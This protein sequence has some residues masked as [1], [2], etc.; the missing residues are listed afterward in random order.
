MATDTGKL[1]EVG[2]GIR[3]GFS[4]CLFK[5]KSRVIKKSI[6][7]VIPMFNLIA[8]K[9]IAEDALIKLNKIIILKL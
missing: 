2:K 7:E 1:V 8:T 3:W 9:Q 5:T 4:S 6:F